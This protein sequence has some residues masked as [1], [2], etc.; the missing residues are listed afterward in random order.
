M[1]ASAKCHLP[2]PT[3]V[4]IIMDG[5]RRWAERRGLT[6]EIGHMQGAKT[7][8]DIMRYAHELG[9]KYLTLFAFSSENWQRPTDE[10]KGILRIIES[11]LDHDSDEL[12]KHGI[13]VSAIGDLKKLPAPI[14]KRLDELMTKTSR[15]SQFF[16]TLALSYGAWEEVVSACKSIAA[17]VAQG[18]L[19]L[20]EISESVLNAHLFTKDIPHPDLFI[21]TSGELRLSNFLLLQMSYS[22]LYF[23]KTLWPDFKR[24]DFDEALN[25]Y[26]SRD[27]RF[28][29]DKRD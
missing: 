5:N 16:L 10:V 9:I 4:A 15:C 25:S 21:R 17:D 8:E 11:Y 18:R 2:F 1:K 12:I 19:T 28:G 29:A 6:S 20:N 22:E 24:R 27:R 26:R 14:R 13:K 7:A 3:S 23:S